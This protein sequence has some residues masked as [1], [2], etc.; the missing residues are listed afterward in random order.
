MSKISELDKE[1]LNTCS[2][3]KLKRIHT[4]EKLVLASNEAIINTN[5]VDNSKFKQKLTTF[6]TDL[7]Q[8]EFDISNGDYVIY[9]YCNELVRQ[10]QQAK[11]EQLLEIENLAGNILGKIKI[12]QNEL[13]KK[14]LNE[15]K[16][17]INNVLSF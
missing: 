11:E 17:E 1:N 4:R 5:S 14:Y 3:K 10:V 15:K 13:T 16:D 6:E 9:E 7:N 8:F 12:Y 2:P